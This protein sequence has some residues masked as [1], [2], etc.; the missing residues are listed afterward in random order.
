MLGRNRLG[1]I[2]VRGT[3]RSV[4]STKLWG[5]VAKG[6]YTLYRPKIQILRILWEFHAYD[7]DP[8]PSEPHGHSLNPYHK[9]KLDVY[10]GEVFGFNSN[11][12]GK[13]SKKDIERLFK[14][15]KFQELIRIA[16]EHSNSH[17]LTRQLLPT[18]GSGFRN[19]YRLLGK[20]SIFYSR[21]VELPF[22]KIIHIS[23]D[24]S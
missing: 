22:S 21:K 14:D 3:R 15:R 10:S 4:R 16:K 19:K 20:A 18:G 2:I 24:H 13:A 17:K 11:L 23:V 8:F 6:S 5:S 12:V 1:R 7:D 9:Y